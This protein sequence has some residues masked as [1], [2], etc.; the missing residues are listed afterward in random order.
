MCLRFAG[1]LSPGAES[2]DYSALWPCLDC[3]LNSESPQNSTR[4]PR[5]PDTMAKVANTGSTK[6]STNGVLYR[7]SLSSH[8]S[9][10][11]EGSQTCVA[12]IYIKLFLLISSTKRPV[13]YR[14][15]GSLF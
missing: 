8:L 13:H 14:D 12:D 7:L 6:Q 10:E 2:E 4:R 3:N 15:Y 1:P 5:T 11:I 9:G